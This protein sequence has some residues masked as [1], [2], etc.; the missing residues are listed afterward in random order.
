MDF[1]ITYGTYYQYLKPKNK[2]D[3]QYNIEARVQ[4]FIDDEMS[5]D[6]PSSVR[7]KHVFIFGDTVYNKTEL[8]FTIDA[9]RRASAGFITVILPYYGFCRAD[10]KGVGRNSLGA[11]VVAHILQALGANRVIAIDLHAD[12]IQLAF[13]IPFEHLAGKHLFESEV[14]EIIARAAIEGKKVLFASPD[15]GGM[16]RVKRFSKMYHLDYVGIEKNREVANQVKS[17]RLLADP[18]EI[19][20]AIIILIDDIVDSGGTLILANETFW[21]YEPA[22]VINI[23][24]HPVMS[25]GAYERLDA[26]GVRIITSNTRKTV[27]GKKS[28]N[29]TYVNINDIMMQ[30]IINIAD[31]KSILK[32]LTA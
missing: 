9:A 1:A 30:A 32:T 15:A 10:K 7:G 22:E 20:D 2:R 6:F 25:K 14:N 12:Q 24:T 11:S 31:N 26:A 16:D 27:V 29:I 19:K 23:I 18:T 28:K 8:E 3:L 13:Q 17:M 4:T 5:V 21:K